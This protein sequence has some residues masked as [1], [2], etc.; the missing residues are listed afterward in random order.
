MQKM[1]PKLKISQDYMGILFSKLGMWCSVLLS[2]QLVSFW[3]SQYFFQCT[4]KEYQNHV[5]SPLQRSTKAQ[6]E[7]FQ[8]YVFLQIVQM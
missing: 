3:G 5:T 8:N 1:E 2:T 7:S 6:V 4:I